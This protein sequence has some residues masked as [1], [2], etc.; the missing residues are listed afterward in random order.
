M[1]LGVCWGGEVGSI[2]RR[3]RVTRHAGQLLLPRSGPGGNR[4]FDWGTGG[5]GGGDR[6]H[7]DSRDGSWM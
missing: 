6:G 5:E 3:F 4:W 7:E 1:R 2:R